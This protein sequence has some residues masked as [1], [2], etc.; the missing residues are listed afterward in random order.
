[1]QHFDSIRREV[2]SFYSTPGIV[3]GANEE[4]KGAKRPSSAL[5]EGQLW[6]EQEGKANTPSLPQP[7]T[8]TQS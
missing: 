6:E 8:D 7:F 2:I 4:T 1:M 5:C 3:D